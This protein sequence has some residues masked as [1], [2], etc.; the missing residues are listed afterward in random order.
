MNSLYATPVTGLQVANYQMDVVANNIANLN[1]S[2]YAAEDPL[3]ASLPAQA[4]IGEPA[5][6]APAPA[7]THVGMGARPG[8]VARSQDRAPIVATGDPRDL[9]IQGPG[10][11]ALRQPSGQV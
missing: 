10:L 11:V 1:S 9:V 2:G 6:L 4:A 7:A 3:V 8:T 5:H